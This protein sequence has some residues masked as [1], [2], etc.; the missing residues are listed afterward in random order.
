MSAALSYIDEVRWQFAKT[1]PEWPHEYA[2]NGQTG[3][4]SS[5]YWSVV[6]PNCAA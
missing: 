5:V 3:E 1:M 4:D 2:V 6:D